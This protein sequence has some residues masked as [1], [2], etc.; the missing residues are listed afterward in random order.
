[1]YIMRGVQLVEICNNVALNPMHWTVNSLIL[2]SVSYIHDFSILES[3]E[4]CVCQNVSDCPKDS[5]P[6]CIS[7][8]VGTMTECEVGARRCAGEQV[9]VI[10]IE[11]CPQ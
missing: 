6:L 5:A 4:Q 8:G 10:S 3:T 7:S 2:V 1:M 11:A 9:D